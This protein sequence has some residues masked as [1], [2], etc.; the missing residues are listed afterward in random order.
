VSWVPLRAAA[1]TAA[2]LLAALSRGDALVLAALLA[3]AAWRPLPAVA[4]VT[5]LVGTAWRWSSTALEDIAGAQAVLGP[6][7][8]VDP[9]A[10]AVAAW[11]GALAV[12]LATPDLRLPPEED[13]GGRWARWVVTGVPVLAHAATAAVIVAGPSIGGDVW[14][15]LLAVV[16][17]VGAVVAVR[18]WVPTTRRTLIEAIAAGAGLV[19]LV[20]V[21]LDAPS[22]DDIADLGAAG[23]GV[24]IAVAAGLLAW[25]TAAA[26][27][28]LHRERQQPS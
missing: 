8:L 12:L 19:S 18:R 16:V 7:G 10:A 24:V 15:R 21:S 26:I 28:H 27:T 22:L 13:P 14:A 6:A 25:A 17:G 2:L 23:E 3:L 9:P 11:L 20:L 4:V 1:L 5:A